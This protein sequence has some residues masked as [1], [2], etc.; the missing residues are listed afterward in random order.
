MTSPLEWCHQGIGHSHYSRCVYLYFYLPVVSSLAEWL[1]GM[2]MKA[3]VTHYW[4]NMSNYKKRHTVEGW[5]ACQFQDTIHFWHRITNITSSI[6]DRQWS[7]IISLMRYYCVL[8]NPKMVDFQGRN[9]FSH[10][11]KWKTHHSLSVTVI[12]DIVDTITINNHSYVT[13]CIPPVSHY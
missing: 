4:G 9:D 10:L 13:H 12:Q 5:L 6:S 11:C 2:V 8:S 1:F 7:P 3:T